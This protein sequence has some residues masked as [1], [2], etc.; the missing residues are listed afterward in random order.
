MSTKTRRKR[1]DLKP[2]DLN[3]P[4]CG[5]S[6]RSWLAWDIPEMGLRCPKCLCRWDDSGKLAYRG[7]S[8]PLLTRT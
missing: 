3:C 5:G 4:H 1:V 7:L 6:F 2:G 8:C